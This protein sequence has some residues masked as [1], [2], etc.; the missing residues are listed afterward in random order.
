MD[1]EG[2]IWRYRLE[3]NQDNNRRP[4]VRGESVW[5]ADD[6]LIAR[7]EPGDASDPQRLTQTYLEQVNANKDFR[8][9]ADAL[10]QVRYLHLVPQLVRD[11]ERY[12]G[13]DRDPFG[14]DFLDQLARLQREHKRTFDSRLSR[15]T[16]A[17][18]VAVPQLEKLKLESDERGT[19]HLRGLYRHWR[20]DA[21]WQTEDQFSD[22]TLRLLGL[23]WALLDGTAPL[24]L[25][26]PELSLHS[27]VVQYIPAMM[28]RIGRKVG[29]QTIVSTHSPDLLSDESISAEEVILLEPSKE[30]TEA[31]IAASVKQV[32]ALLTGGA[33]V[34]EAVLPR[35]APKGAE[36]LSLLFAQGNG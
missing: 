3:F 21:G 20:P 4:V 24:L 16:E 30:G 22:G 36:Q 5:R 11:R 31:V 8:E 6:E 15:I 9:V 19:P 7:P 1:I 14:G 34:G 26:E 28:W 35:T 23:L 10:S 27:A 29:R 33:T 13:R 25:E 12:V 32:R 18:R 17:L 2:V